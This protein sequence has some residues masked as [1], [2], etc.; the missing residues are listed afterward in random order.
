MEKVVFRTPIAKDTRSFRDWTGIFNRRQEERKI[1]RGVPEHVEIEIRSND[2]ILI[3]PFG[4]VHGGGEDV[5]YNRFSEELCAAVNTPRV[6]ALTLGDLTDSYFWGRDAQDEQIAAFV[7]QNRFL[8]SGLFMLGEK[9]KLLA[10]WKGDHDGWAGGMGE[11]L[12]STFSKEFGAHYFEGLSYVTLKV[13]TQ[14]YKIAGAHRH[15]GYSIYNKAHP[16]LRAY[17]DDAEGSDIVITAHTH[18]KGYLAQPIKR[19]GGKS[20]IGH[21]ISIGAYKRSDNYARKL[22][23]HVK[24]DDEMGPQAILLYPKVKKIRVFWTVLD[25]IEALHRAEFLAKKVGG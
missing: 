9:K 14:T 2:P 4:D 25:G 17:R 19:F 5:D 20:G 18:D 21:F 23:F 16:A 22:G 7:E 24:D 11:T 13:G 15:P 1:S 3:I 6:F 8:R 12:Y 10:G